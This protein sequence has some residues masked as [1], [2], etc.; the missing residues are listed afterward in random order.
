MGR[1]PA[2][3]QSVSHVDSVVV[4]PFHHR[5]EKMASLGRSH[6]GSFGVSLA[7]RTVVFH[8]YRHDDKLPFYFLQPEDRR[9]F[10]SQRHPYDVAGDDLL[11]D[12]L[13]FGAAIPRAL[14]VI[15]PGKRWTLL[16]QDWEAA[17]AVLAMADMPGRSR[18]FVT[19][20]NSYDCIVS[21]EHLSYFGVNPDSCPGGTILQRALPLTE[22]PVFTVSEQFAHDLTEDVLQT[23]VMAPQ[24]QLTLKPRIVG[25]DNGPFVDPAVD[26]AAL[27]AAESGNFSPLADWKAAHRNAFQAALSSLQPGADRPVWG[28]ISRFDRD[29]AP[30]FVMAGRDDS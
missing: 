25:I 7:D 22:L 13:L 20:H 6:E 19:L 15:N 27:A 4:T 9:I 21:S 26:A 29:D 11:H 10:A 12:A 3:V 1:L 14:H 23:Q 16:L 17:T 28:D 5:I 18:S 8:V 2:K 30:W 24:L